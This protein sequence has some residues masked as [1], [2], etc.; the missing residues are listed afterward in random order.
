MSEQDDE[1]T[2]RDKTIRVVLCVAAVAAVF[3]AVFYFGYSQG[4]ESKTEKLRKEYQDKLVAIEEKTDKELNK[5]R[6][7]ADADENK[8]REPLARLE[9]R[10]NELEKRKAKAGETISARTFA[11]DEEG[12]GGLSDDAMQL[13][14]AS[15]KI[16]NLCRKV[17]I[18]H[19]ALGR[20][21][22][23]SPTIRSSSGMHKEI[24]DAHKQIMADMKYA[25]GVNAK[26]HE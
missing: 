16:G 20:S 10:M 8:E 22:F 21:L 9:A 7:K 17:R 5:I 6:Q 25:S 3:G 18:L 15:V 12:M 14:K 23:M 1:M 4:H 13:E 19:V 26:L 11:T 2:F 24:V